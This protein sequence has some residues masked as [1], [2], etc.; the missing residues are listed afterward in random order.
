MKIGQLRKRVSGFEML[1]IVSLFD[2]G[3]MF[4]IVLLLIYFDVY[5]DNIFVGLF[6]FLT[7]S[8]Y[9][10]SKH[11]QVFRDIKRTHSPAVSIS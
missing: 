4:I 10:K 11:T 7:A 8:S 1:I 6:V 5:F 2:Y 3:I 9:W